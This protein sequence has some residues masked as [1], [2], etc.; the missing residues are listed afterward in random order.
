M[1]ARVPVLRGLTSDTLEYPV[2]NASMYGLWLLGAAERVNLE[3]ARYPLD[4]FAIVFRE[5]LSNG[6]EL[7][8]TLWPRGNV[9]AGSWGNVY[10]NLC[11]RLSYVASRS[12]AI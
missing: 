5:W 4:R 3:P 1:L 6:T 7:L 11:C 8:A 2:V 9:Y 12:A 10:G